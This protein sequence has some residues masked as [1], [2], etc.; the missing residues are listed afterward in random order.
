MLDDLFDI[1]SPVILVLAR[2]L[3]ASLFLLAAA[4]NALDLQGFGDFLEAGGVP[5]ILAGPVFYFQI[6]GGLAIVL[7]WQTRLAALALAGFCFSSGIWFY[8]D[9]SDPIQMT[10]LLKNIALTGG[11]LGLTAHGAGP[12]S[13]DGRV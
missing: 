4:S 7:G 10:C 3:L 13:I 9:L 5:R 11:F 6:I 1:L 8:D 2:L 12:I